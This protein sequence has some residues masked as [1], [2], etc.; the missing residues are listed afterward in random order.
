MGLMGFMDWKGKRVLVTG[1]SGFKGS[2]LS[3]WLHHLGARVYGLS[4]PPTPG[5]HLFDVLDLSPM[6][7][8]DHRGDI[9]DPS[10]VQSAF[11]HA[12]PEVVFHLAAQPLVRASYAA[13]EETFHTNVTGTA[14]ILGACRNQKVRAVVCVTTDKCYENHEWIHPYREADRLGGHDPYSASKACAELVAASYRSSFQ[15]G[16]GMPPI[17][18]ARAGNVIG[19]GD[20]SPDRLVPDCL[21]AFVES[22]PVRLRY[23]HAVRP[24]QHV[25]EPLSGYLLCAQNLLSGEEK[26]SAW[27]FGP[28][29][30]GEATVGHVANRLAQLWG[31]PA[32][33]D[34]TP[35]EEN[36][37]EA[38]T[39]RL[40][41]SKAQ[42]KLGWRPQWPLE[43]ALAETVVWHQAFANGRNMRDFT[44]RQIHDYQTGSHS[45]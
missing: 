26:G 35:T 14:R 9:T 28:D 37:H 22:R 41:S 8:G 20:W 44:L 16:G 24:W 21:R 17:H 18:T 25:L 29:H 27:N 11:D 30:S 3:F 34:A 23:P 7:E 15:N 45:S 32:S 33:V 6:I 5:P 12:Q 42:L 40:D 1:H 4:L 10:A 31:P 36:Y 39:L 19:G 13:P 2:W 43:R 38:Q